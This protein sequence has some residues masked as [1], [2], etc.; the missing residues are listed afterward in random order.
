MSSVQPTS[1]PDYEFT[2]TS[3]WWE[4]NR[5]GRTNSNFSHGGYR[6]FR[7]GAMRSPFFDFTSILQT[8]VF[9]VV[10]F[11]IT[12]SV[13][14]KKYLSESKY[15]YYIDNFF[16][17]MAFASF[18]SIAYFG[19]GFEMYPTFASAMGGLMTCELGFAIGDAF[20]NSYVS[21]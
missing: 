21:E 11:I 6:Y 20:S 4:N 5:R 18:G 9:I 7:L 3:T 19:Y 8:L 16:R 17:L 1:N 15:K 12:T 14:N 2:G 13:L 10:A